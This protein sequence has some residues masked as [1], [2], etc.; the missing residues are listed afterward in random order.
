MRTHPLIA[1]QQWQHGPGA[2]ITPREPQVCIH[3]VRVYYAEQPVSCRAALWTG[4]VWHVRYGTTD[5]N[6]WVGI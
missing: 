3:S 6:S 1:V 5:E 2:H 4:L